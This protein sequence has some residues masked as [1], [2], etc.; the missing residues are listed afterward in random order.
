MIKML[1]ILGLFNSIFS[2]SNNE[3]VNHDYLDNQ[4]SLSLIDFKSDYED[5]QSKQYY[6]G[7]NIHDIANKL[8]KYLKSTLKDKGEFIVEYSME[9][10]MDPYLA[11]AVMLQET[12]CYW[13]C[14][15]LTRVCNNVGGNKGKPGC[16]GGSYRRFDTIEEGIKFAI[17]KLNSYYKKGLTTTEQIGPKYASD[18][19]WPQRVNN[20]I[21][22]LK[23]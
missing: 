15:Y 7:E 2:N 5:F 17:N 3:L 12:G 13:R 6:N 22:K 16:N 11:T 10:G 18:P 14:S 20:Y 8:N 4:I 23:K 19:K 9:V 21:K 1:L